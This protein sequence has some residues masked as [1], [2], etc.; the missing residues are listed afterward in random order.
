MLT[1]SFIIEERFIKAVDEGSAKSIV[2]VLKTDLKVT[3]R[4]VSSA[5]EDVAAVGTADV[6]NGGAV[7]VDVAIVGAAGVVVFGS[8]TGFAVE[9]FQKNLISICFYFF[10]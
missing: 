4:V 3:S 8:I 5:L 9:H 10:F 2:Y 6:I 1:S 7:V